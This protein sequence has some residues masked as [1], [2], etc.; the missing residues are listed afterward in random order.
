MAVE[1]LLPHA[2][3]RHPGDALEGRD[4]RLVEKLSDHRHKGFVYDPANVSPLD[5]QV[6]LTPLKA[7]SVK[8]PRQS[9]PR[10]L[11]P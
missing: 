9:H 7:H 4:H 2:C 8:A 1:G 10:R 3:V 6:E 11:F 5:F